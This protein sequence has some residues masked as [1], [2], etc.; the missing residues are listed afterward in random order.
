MRTRPVKNRI[1]STPRILKQSANMASILKTHAVDSPNALVYDADMSNGRIA[2]SFFFFFTSREGVAVSL[3]KK[4]K[5]QT[6]KA[7][8]RRGFL[9]VVCNLRS[10]PNSDCKPQY[11]ETAM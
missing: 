4:T 9:F 7:P 5:Q 1:S 2:A 8:P 11:R 10:E 3:L 6:R